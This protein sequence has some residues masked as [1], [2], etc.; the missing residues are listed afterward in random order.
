MKTS[1]FE[2]ETD[3]II[4][5]RELAALSLLVLPLVLINR[6]SCGRAECFIPDVMDSAMVTQHWPMAL[7]LIGLIRVLMKDSNA[8]DPLRIPVYKSVV[9]DQEPDWLRG[10]VTTDLMSRTSCATHDHLLLLRRVKTLL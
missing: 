3:A 8:G 10:K 4:A 5:S 7:K 2:A 9:K 6:E 1:P